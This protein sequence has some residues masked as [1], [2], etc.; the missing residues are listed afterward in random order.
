[1]SEVKEREN[2]RERIM[3]RRE[4]PSSE[5]LRATARDRARPHARP[6]APSRSHLR[7]PSLTRSLASLPPPQLYAALSLLESR[8]DAR[9]AE[10]ARAEQRVSRAREAGAALAR[11][12]FEEALQAKDAALRLARAQMAEM[13]EALRGGTALGVAAAVGAQED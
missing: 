8:A 2:D 11:A 7:R 3:Q 6:C 13:E 12:R 1:M 10:L 5:R 9:E 4:R